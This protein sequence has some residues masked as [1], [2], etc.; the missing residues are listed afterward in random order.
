MGDCNVMRANPWNGIV[1][2]GHNNGTVRACVRAC[3]RAA[4]GA[5]PHTKL[6][7]HAVSHRAT[8]LS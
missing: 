7:A 4:L 1:H 5:R 6:T 2:L 3:V 8:A